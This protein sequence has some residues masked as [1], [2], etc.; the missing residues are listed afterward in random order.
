LSRP[1]SGSGPVH[2]LLD[3]GQRFPRLDGEHHTDDEVHDAEQYPGVDVR[4]WFTEYAIVQQ[5]TAWM[6][7]RIWRRAT[8]PT[9][10]TLRDARPD[11]KVFFKA[12][13]RATGW[14]IQGAPLSVNAR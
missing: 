11:A 5:G 3:L 1:D 8:G 13:T 6:L 12:G 4:A 10:L 7:R 14:S 9:L 2:E